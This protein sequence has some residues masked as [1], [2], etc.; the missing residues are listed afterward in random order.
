MMYEELVMRLREAPNDWYDADLHYEAADAI[1]KL[2]DRIAASEAIIE[3]Q[4]NIIKAKDRDLQ[5]AI[6]AASRTA[7]GG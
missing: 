6:A 4:S 5:R 1:E 3:R 7:E 2:Q